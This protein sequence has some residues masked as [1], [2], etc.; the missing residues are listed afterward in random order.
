LFG[1]E[2]YPLTPEKDFLKIRIILE[3][4][5]ACL[6]AL[7]KKQKKLEGRSGKKAIKTDRVYYLLNV[8]FF[9]FLGKGRS[10]SSSVTRMT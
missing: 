9:L 1:L 2:K 10:P 3:P 6:T 8:F 7:P 5:P 4:P